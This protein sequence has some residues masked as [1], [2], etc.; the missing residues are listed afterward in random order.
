MMMISSAIM[1]KR[2]AGCGS[3]FPPLSISPSDLDRNLEPKPDFNFI[4]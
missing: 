1:A 3:A 2:V 4:A